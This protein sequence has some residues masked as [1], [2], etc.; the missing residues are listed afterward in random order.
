VIIEDLWVD[1]AYVIIWSMYPFLKLIMG[2]L[3]VIAF[4]ESIVQALLILRG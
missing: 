1:L 2:G 3:L 4:A